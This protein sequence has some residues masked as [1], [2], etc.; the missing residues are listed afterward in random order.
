MIRLQR[1]RGSAEHPEKSIWSRL[2]PRNPDDEPASVLL[3][4]I[5][6][7]KKERTLVAE[8]KGKKK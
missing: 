8:S 1:Q 5:Q 4:R 3:K 2:V 6:T 7:K